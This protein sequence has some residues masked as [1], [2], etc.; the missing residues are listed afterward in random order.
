M[1]KKLLR[2]FLLLLGSILLLLAVVWFSGTPAPANGFNRHFL[3]GRARLIRSLPLGQPEFYIAGSDSQ[4]IYLANYA[5]TRLLFSCTNNLEHGAYRRIPVVD[6]GKFAWRLLHIQIDS[7]TVWLMEG[8]TPAIFK[9]DLLFQTG[10]RIKTASRNFTAS[11]VTGDGDVVLKTFDDKLGQE[12]LRKESTHTANPKTY[13]PE[14]QQDGRFSVD[15]QLF[16]TPNANRLIFIY[17]YRNEWICLDTLLRI[18][19]T[20]RTM[21]TN[22]YAKLII[23]QT[24]SGGQQTL[25]VPPVLV[26]RKACAGQQFLLVASGLRADNESWMASKKN[27]VI[28]VYPLPGGAYY[29]SFYL[30]GLGGKKITGMDLFGQNL[31]VVT[32]DAL[33]LYQLPFRDG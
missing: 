9:T 31:I 17:Y 26:N 12:I 22:R 10:S 20:G 1:T 30:E 11:V 18:E 4:Q 25:L 29:G 23:G 6:T 3:A 2:L 13:T 15:G 7:P 24:G 16:R 33:N 27:A 19:K 28:D 14:K 8:L 5:D 21:D 32:N